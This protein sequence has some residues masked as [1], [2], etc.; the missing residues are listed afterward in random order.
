MGTS[1][2]TAIRMKA[3]TTPSGIQRMMRRAVNV[4]GRRTSRPSW[5]MTGV[6]RL[7]SLL[8]VASIG[9]GVQCSCLQKDE[10]DCADSG[11]HVYISLL[12]SADRRHLLRQRL[13]SSP[14]ESSGVSAP[15]NL[16]LPPDHL[17]HT[18]VIH[19]NALHNHPRPPC[20][21]HPALHRASEHVPRRHT[22]IV[23][24]GLGQ[25]SPRHRF[26]LRLSDARHSHKHREPEAEQTK[27]GPQEQQRREPEQARRPKE[28]EHEVRE[29]VDV[30]KERASMISSTSASRKEWQQ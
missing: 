10:N 16:E 28:N 6:G 7:A 23:H 1:R 20:H 18:K 13:L 15:A 24:I 9:N 26:D 17:V 4:V 11:L 22:H 29:R 2:P 19:G 27:H 21:H 3:I 12:T 30:I 5:M 8:C 14:E 25:H